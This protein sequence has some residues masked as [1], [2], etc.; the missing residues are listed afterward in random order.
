[1]TKTVKAPLV[2]LIARLHFYIGLFVGPFIFIAAFTGVIYVVT[3]AAENYVYKNQL[4]TDS[5]GE[6]HSLADQIA[7]A[8]ASLPE[9]LA[10]EAVRSSIGEGHTSRVLFKNPSLYGSELQTVFV[11]PVTLAVKGH[12]ATYG[13][14]GILPLRIK[15]DYLHR[16]LL[17][18]EPGRYYS[19]LAASWLWISALGGLIIWWHSRRKYARANQH[20][21]FV[22]ARVNHSNLGLIILLGLFFISA[23]GLTWSKWAGGKITE[24]RT[25]VGWET[26]SLSLDSEPLSQNFPIDQPHTTDFDQAK[27]ELFDAVLKAGRDAGID[28]AKLEIRP[29]SSPDKAWKIREI[30]RSWPTQVDSVAVDPLTMKVVSQVNF[31]DFPIVAKLIRWGIDG[32]M[33]VLFG[34][35]NQL[36]LA[37]FGLSLC[38]MVVWGYRMWWVRRPPAGSSVKTFTQTWLALSPGQRVAVLLIAVFLGY[39]MPVMGTSLVIFVIIDALRWKVVQQKQAIRMLG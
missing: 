24:W 1:M 16:Q 29:S 36:L 9:D 11:D 8:R 31:K 23:T 3:P 38:M 6:F 18:G 2:T 28:A 26:P 20:N 30:D 15:L 10:L 21:S 25:A 17:V 19:E 14:S 13:T 5:R 33:G 39:A 27:D 12:F 32:H 4:T 7:A 34:L 37:A 22:K 35:P